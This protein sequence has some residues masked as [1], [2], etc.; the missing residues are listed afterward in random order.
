MNAAS[1]TVPSSAWKATGWYIFATL[2]L[3][4]P[5]VTGLTRDIPWDLGDSL[6]NSWILAWDADH[7]LRFLGGDFSALR[8]FWNANIFG[9]EPLALAYSEHLLALAVPILPVYAA[10]RNLILCYNLLF[11]STFVLSGLGMYLL[12]RD[13]TRSSGAAFVA[14]LIYA[15]APYR[16]GQFSHL[17][18]LSSQWM[19]FALF[20]LRR[21]FE[22]QSQS[23]PPATRALRPAQGTPGSSRGSRLPAGSLALA[24]ASAALV[25]Q[26]LSC[27]Y[28]VFFFFPFVIAYVLFEIGSRR[29]WRDRSVWIALSVAAIGVIATTVPFLWPYLELRRRGLAPRSLVEV[30]SY[31]ADVFSYL[32]AHGAHRLYGERIRG[33]PKPE[34]DLFPGFV[35]VLLAAVGVGAH[36]WSLWR[37]APRGATPEKRWIFRTAAALCILVVLLLMNILVTGGLETSVAGVSFRARS[38]FRLLAVG[39]IALAVM[40]WRSP[41]IRAIVRGAPGSAL[42][43]YVAALTA[44]FWMSLGPVPESMGR[45]LHDPG[46]YL[47][48]YDYVPGFDGLRVPA[49]FGMVF[50]MFLPVLSG[51]GAVHLERRFRRGSLVVVALGIVFLAEVNAA[52]INVNGTADSTA[53]RRLDAYVLPGPATFEIYHAV[54]QLPADV[55]IAEFPFG[56]NAYDLRY[57]YYS[58]THWRRLLN[59]YSGNFPGWYIDAQEIL[60]AVPNARLDEAWRFLSRVG[61]THAIVHERAFLTDEGPRTSEWLRARGAREIANDGGD[62]LFQLTTRE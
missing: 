53:L 45:P 5:T 29:L 19:P 36:A 2:A 20:A 37:S 35:P 40:M 38:A 28:F 39:L 21:F 54:S 4:W 9:H 55:V 27:G 62:R 15:F 10:T 61:T 42:A 60:K 58:T 16:L 14:G 23:L 18:V 17:Q 26:N 52:P 25:A 24:G 57:M 22:N 34:G 1:A 56:D 30:I 59:G 31:S 6:L 51:F 48:F 13:L 47:F 33:F 3:T 8:G 43:F 49:R 41:C 7:L 12:V 46:L 11:L 32:T 50:M 44:C